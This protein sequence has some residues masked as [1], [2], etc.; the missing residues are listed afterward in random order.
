MKIKMS[1]MCYENG[2]EMGGKETITEWDGV[3]HL[4]KV[5]KLYI[6]ESFLFFYFIHF[7][8]VYVFIPGKMFFKKKILKKRNCC[9]E[10]ASLMKYEII[11]STCL[12]NT[13]IIR[14]FDKE[15]CIS[16]NNSKLYWLN[17]WILYVVQTF[18]TSFT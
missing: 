14:I 18:S 17:R 16:T 2:V 6:E 3:H 5:V 11:F 4:L 10:E 8:F 15:N 7:L 12:E 13:W 9:F 1:D